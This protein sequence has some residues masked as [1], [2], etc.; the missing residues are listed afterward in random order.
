MLTDE[1]IEVAQAEGQMTE[2]EDGAFDE[3]EEEG[4]EPDT[5]EENQS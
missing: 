5:E 4:D 3:I 1:L 2:L